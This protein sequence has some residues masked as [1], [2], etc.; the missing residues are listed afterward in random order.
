MSMKELVDVLRENAVLKKQVNA[1]GLVIQQQRE[2]IRKLK[3]TKIAL[4]AG[5]FAAD[6]D[7]NQEAEKAKDFMQSPIEIFNRTIEFL[8][9]S[10]IPG[11]SGDKAR[12]LLGDIGR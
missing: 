6:V 3:S 2:L 5:R 12:E 11:R 1:Q 4:V 9:A 8:K 10:A 7:P